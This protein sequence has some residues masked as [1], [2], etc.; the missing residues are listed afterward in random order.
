MADGITKA[1][2]DARTRLKYYTPNICQEP[3]EEGS[4][5]GAVPIKVD[6]DDFEVDVKTNNANQV[7]PLRFRVVVVRKEDHW[8]VLS[9]LYQIVQ[10]AKTRRGQH[11][12]IPYECVTFP[13]HKEGYPPHLCTTDEYLEGGIVGQARFI[14]DSLG[15]FRADMEDLLK[16]LRSMKDRY[17]ERMANR[18]RGMYPEWG[19]LEDP[20]G[21]TLVK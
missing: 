21:K 1:G 15:G 8:V 10:A 6:G 18:I 19:F 7:R 16:D 4:K 12:E 5:K 14:R 3:L 13:S 20:L 2:L 17:D 11:N 9:P